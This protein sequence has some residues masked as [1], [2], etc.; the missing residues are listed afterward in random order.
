MTLP[1]FT[2]LLPFTFQRPAL[3]VSI[4]QSFNSSIFQSLI[5]QKNGRAPDVA[6]A[7]LNLLRATQWLAS[8]LPGTHDPAVEFHLVFPPPVIDYAALAPI[9]K[10]QRPS[11]S[12]RPCAYRLMKGV[13]QS[14]EVP[15][16]DAR[17]S[18]C[19]GC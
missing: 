12:S 18:S 15:Q 10:C 5:F 7:R 19:S 13:T 8:Q 6:T 9:P 4:V 2:F 17:P 16:T 14:P 1:A 11:T 3:K